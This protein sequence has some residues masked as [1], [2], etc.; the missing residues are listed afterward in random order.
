MKRENLIVTIV[1]P[2]LAALVLIA[3][4]GAVAALQAGPTEQAEC[5]ECAE[6]RQ[7][8]MLWTGSANYWRTSSQSWKSRYDACRRDRKVSAAPVCQPRQPARICRRGIWRRCR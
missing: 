8:V 4:G 1:G 5:P 7:A 6:L 3:G 2:V